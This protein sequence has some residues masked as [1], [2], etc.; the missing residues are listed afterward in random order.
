[1]GYGGAPSWVYKNQIASLSSQN[2]S[3]ASDISQLGSRVKELE[4]ENARLKAELEK[5]KKKAKWN[6]RTKLSERTVHLFL[7]T[8][9]IIARIA[10]VAAAA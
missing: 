7:L 6:P 8:Y 1:M 9:A 3:N 5:C 4:D 2:F 10:S